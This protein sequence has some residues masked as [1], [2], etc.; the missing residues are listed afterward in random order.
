MY[1][2]RSYYDKSVI[3]GLLLLAQTA[4]FA[5]QKP[6]IIWLMA[7]DMSLDL[8]CYGMKAVKTPVLNKMANEGVRFDHCYVT[9]YNFV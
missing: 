8:E 9:S 3:T 2:I 6:N 7:E 1:A 5:Q 4:A